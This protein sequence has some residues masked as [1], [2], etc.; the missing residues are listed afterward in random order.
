MGR[1][2]IGGWICIVAGVLL[3][4]ALFA[5]VANGRNLATPTPTPD[6]AAFPATTPPCPVT[7]P[8]GSTPPGERSSPDHYGNGVLWTSLWPNGDVLI[9]QDLLDPDGELGMKF[10]WWR[11]IRG[12]LAIEGRRLDA[13]APPLIADVPDGYGQTGFQASGLIFPTDGCWEITGRVDGASLTFVVR[14]VRIDIWEPPSPRQLPRSRGHA[15]SH[16]AA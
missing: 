16:L 10:P 12:Q 8:N 11:G 6:A 13:P 14:V 4:L 5:A 1:T 2:F 7:V 9:S 15:S 3:T